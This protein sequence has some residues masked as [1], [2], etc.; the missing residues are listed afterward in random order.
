MRQFPSCIKSRI[1]SAH[2]CSLLA[3]TSPRCNP[4]G[5]PMFFCPPLVADP[6]SAPGCSPALSEVPHK[7]RPRIFSTVS[8]FSSAANVDTRS[9][10]P[11]NRQDGESYFHCKWMRFHMS[12][13]VKDCFVVLFL[14]SCSEGARDG[15]LQD[16]SDGHSEAQ[17]ADSVCVKNCRS[18]PSKS[19]AAP[20]SGKFDRNKKK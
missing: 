20:T 13:S 4:G 6:S 7:V 2:Y 5:I 18:S 14:V 11:D 3:G 15:S 19:R 1:I 12:N 8:F 16:A 10:Y 9:L 17:I